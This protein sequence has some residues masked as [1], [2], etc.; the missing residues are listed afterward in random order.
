M[1]G[2]DLDLAGRRA[3]VTAASGGLG[4]ATASAL[5]AEGAT[6]TICS[7]DLARAEEAASRIASETGGT[8]HAFA[9]DVAS[10]TDLERLVAAAAEAMGGLEVLVNNAGGPPPGGFADLDDAK[11]E[12]GFQLTLMSVVRTTRLALPHMERS[13]GGSILTIMSS[14]VKQPIPNLLISNVYRPGLVGL[15]KSLAIDLAPRGIRVNGLAPG[16]IAT[17][18]TKQLD[19]AAAKKQGKSVEEVRAAS[20]ASI[21]MGRLGEPAEFGR[22][23][24]FLS[25]PAASYVTGQVLIA[26]GGSVRAL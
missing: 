23:A 20:V 7:R 12:V 11:W 8:V 15:T 4:Y 19:E 14:S 25:S 5:A 24:A 6:V 21:P 16:R 17:E 9:A 10:A 1:A 26:D 3:L 13:G 2:M 18:R 22:V